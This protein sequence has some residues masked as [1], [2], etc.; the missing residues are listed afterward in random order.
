MNKTKYDVAIVEKPGVSG[1]TKDEILDLLE[2]MGSKEV[3]P[4][5]FFAKEHESSAMGFVD[6]SSMNVV[7]YDYDGS[8][9]SSFVA[10][11]LDDMENETPNGEYS[12]NGLSI[13]ITR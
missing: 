5:E 10:D 11:I 1:L 7:D 4:V 13:R 9:L 2:A 12:F 3:Y 6:A 8:G